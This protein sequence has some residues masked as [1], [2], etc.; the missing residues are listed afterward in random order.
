MQEQKREILISLFVM[1][2]ILWDVTPCSPVKF[3]DVSD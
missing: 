3:T 1:S 2:T